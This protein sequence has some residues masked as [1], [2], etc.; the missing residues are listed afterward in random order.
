[1]KPKTQNIW[2]TL[3]SD[4]TFDRMLERFNRKIRDKKY[5]QEILSHRY[6]EKPSVTKRKKLNKAKLV[7]KYELTQLQEKEDKV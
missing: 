6:Y 7:R 2:V 3:K 1:M 5:M 4:E